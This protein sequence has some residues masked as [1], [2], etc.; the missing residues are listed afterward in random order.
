MSKKL[1]LPRENIFLPFSTPFS[2]DIDK[3]KCHILSYDLGFKKA[4]DLIK[5]DDSCEWYMWQFGRDSFPMSWQLH[6]DMHAY[7]SFES[8]APLFLKNDLHVLDG[9]KEHVLLLYDL[10]LRKA[11]VVPTLEDKID[12]D[13]WRPK[14]ILIPSHLTNFKKKYY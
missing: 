6:V 4:C 2:C 11:C 1:E 3:E 7:L 14:G 8:Y 5:L 10:K 9:T 12:V 13:R